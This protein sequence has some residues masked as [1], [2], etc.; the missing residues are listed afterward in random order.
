MTEIVLDDRQAQILKSAPGKV[1]IVDATG[2]TLAVVE[3]SIFT[4][5]QVA[6]ARARCNSAGPWYTTQQVLERL[7]SL[8]KK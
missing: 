6:E 8:A 1:K 5:E 7:E 4:P 3:K 2:V